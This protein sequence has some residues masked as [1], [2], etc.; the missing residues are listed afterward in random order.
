[1]LLLKKRKQKTTNTGEYW[2]PT[3]SNWDGRK[4]K[5]KNKYL[6]SPSCKI[7]RTILKINNGGN[8]TD[9]TKNKK[10]D[11]DAQGLTSERWGRQT[12]CS[13]KR[14]RKKTSHY[15]GLHRWN[16]QRYFKTLTEKIAREKIWAKKGKFPEGSWI[17]FNASTKIMSWLIL[18]KIDNIQK[19]SMHFAVT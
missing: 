11:N 4:I 18:S 13:K 10:I 17:S 9:R 6:S 12:L 19:N 7:L 5:P 3:M 15:W 1:M 16:K 8:Q 2:K 14:R